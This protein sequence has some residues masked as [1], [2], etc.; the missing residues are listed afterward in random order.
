MTKVRF[1]ISGSPTNRGS[2]L[3]K[4]QRF[5]NCFPESVT[6]PTTQNQ[7]VYLLKRD[8]AEFAWQPSGGTAEGRAIYSW[9]GKVYSVIGD[10][11]YST[12][13]AGTSTAIKTL[14][15]STGAVGIT[16]F[17]AANDYLVVVDGTKGYYISTT[18]V[19]T[20][21]TDPQFPTPHLPYPVFMDGYIFLQKTTGEIFNC[22]V[23]DITAWQSTS[24][25]TPES[26]PDGA[27]AICRQNNLLTALGVNSVEFFY[28]AANP[29]PGSPLG[30]NQQA[31]IQYGCASGSSVAQE[32]GLVIFVAQS[33]TG[34][35]FVVAVEGTKDNTISTEAVNRILTG[36]GSNI[37]DCW[38]YLTRQKGHLMYVLNLP[39]QGRTLVFDMHTKM[40]H[41]WEWFDGST[42]SVFPMVD[43]TEFQ[44]LAIMLHQA[45][46]KIYKMKPGVYQD[47]SRALKVLVQTSRFDGESANLKFNSRMEVLA[48]WQTS[49]SNLT[50]YWSD[51]DYKTWTSGRTIDLSTRSYLYRCG[52]F[53]R[54]SWRLY[55][56]AN[57][58]LRLYALELELD[59]GV[60]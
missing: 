28:D 24:Y 43:T 34:E 42:D 39:S 3:E 4:D 51:D 1:P 21:I 27:V 14:T 5:V 8:G 12:T 6:N 36:E 23:T 52:S 16:E 31:I 30:R 15:T 58:P 45:N 33:A 25:I 29:V 11:L 56:E 13:G 9:N 53:R 47:D 49:T 41:E 19:V 59:S 32:E 35:K 18:D 48:D 60:H 37:A 7:K 20:E 22:D 40:W 46:G 17:T 26:Y 50:V 55:S 57:T 38:G 44:D 54:R 10:K 2:D